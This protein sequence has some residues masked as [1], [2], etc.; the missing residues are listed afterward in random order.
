MRPV[1]LYTAALGDQVWRWCNSTDTVTSGGDDFEPIAAGRGNLSEGEGPLDI[2]LPITHPFPQT[3]VNS[4]PGAHAVLTIQWVD[5]ED[6]GSLRIIY[7]GMLKAL[8]VSKDGERANMRLESVV[9]SFKKESPERS[10]S[11][12]CQ[13]FLYDD[14]CAVNKDDFKHVA[15]VTAVSGNTLTVNGLAAKG[16]GWA[17]PG[18]VAYGTVDYRQIVSQAGDVVTLIL[19]FTVDLLGETVTVYAGCDHAI[20]TCEDKFSNKVNFRGCPFVPT[21]NIFATGLK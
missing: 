11:P 18:Y 4:A 5:R 19:P 14:D 9:A 13:A 1:E 21:K 7:K 3:Y 2:Y 16:A 8:S 15:N 20:T 6:I 17:L 12:Q 10:F